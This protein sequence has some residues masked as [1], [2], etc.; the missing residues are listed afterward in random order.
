MRAKSN[1][2]IEFRSRCHRIDNIRKDKWVGVWVPIF[3][4][5]VG[6]IIYP[7]ALKERRKNEEKIKICVCYLP[8]YLL[9]S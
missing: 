2:N 9:H 7:A 1:L 3:Q 6:G 5:R 8:Y 4:E